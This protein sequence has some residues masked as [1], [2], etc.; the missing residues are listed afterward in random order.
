MLT[1]FQLLSGKYG[2]SGCSCPGRG[3]N[4][5]RKG[6][7]SVAKLGWG[8][9]PAARGEDSRGRAAPGATARGRRAACGVL[10]GLASLLLA[11]GAIGLSRHAEVLAGPL[12]SP[13]APAAGALPLDYAAGSSRIRAA[14]PDRGAAVV[15]SDAALRR[16]LI[17]GI[18]LV[19]AFW[20]T[21]GCGAQPR[22]GR[23]PEDRGVAAGRAV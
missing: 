21:A 18:L 22:P 6:L 4:R 14:L 2:D 9:S 19:A 20:A 3:G 8:W 7:S 13:V 15:D 11:V 1:T 10:A 23:G 17:A 5:P 12:F 16:G